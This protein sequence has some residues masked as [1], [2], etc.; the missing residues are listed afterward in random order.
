MKN[1]TESLSQN[2]LIQI[3]SGN[4]TAATL[5]V[6]IQ[7]GLNAVALGG[8][9]YSVNY[10]SVTMKLTITESGGSGFLVYSDHILQTLGL[11]NPSNGGFYD[12]TTI[13]NPMSIQNILNTPNPGEPSPVFTSG[14]IILNRIHELYLRSGGLGNF[15]TLDPQGNVNVL[16]KIPVN[17][18]FGE[19][20][21][22]P[23][24]FN[25]SDL[26][27]VGGRCLSQIDFQLT[28]V[29]SNVV[30]LHNLPVSFTLAFVYADL[31]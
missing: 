11:K 17:A 29:Y 22:T 16:K 30:D 27:D 15:K 3:A 24:D 2:K 10:S 14:V 21:T 26:I 8:A 19:V 18:N 7:S 4:Y 12:G 28:D 6:A 31:E 5:A 1:S 20:I 23:D 13:T 9:S 25:E